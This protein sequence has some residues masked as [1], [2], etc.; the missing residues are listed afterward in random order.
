MQ[1][2]LVAINTIQ[3]KPTPL[4]QIDQQQQLYKV[5]DIQQ[6]ANQARICFSGTIKLGP[7]GGK[8]GNSMEF[9]P[10]T[11]IT[12]ITAI[13]IGYGEVLNALQFTSTD[14]KSEKWGTGDLTQTVRFN[15]PD[16]YLN[17]ISGTTTKNNDKKK[18]FVESLTFY[19]NKGKQYT[20]GPAT[21]TG[22]AFS[23]PMANAEV[24]GF[25]GRAG[26]QI[27]AIGIYVIP[28]ESCP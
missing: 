18:I 8:G 21:K 9:E 1:V 12:S 7:W 2:E 4:I 20:Y 16:E 19:T 22:D 26:D 10:D 14:K 28:H 17:L 6:M 13:D 25:S 23:I 3:E 24:V 11:N 5:F 15:G 27:N